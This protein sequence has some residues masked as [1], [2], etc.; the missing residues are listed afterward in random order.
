MKKK[1][2]VILSFIMLA[3]CS[4]MF[5]PTINTKK[6]AAADTSTQYASEYLYDGANVYFSTVSGG[7]ADGYGA[8]TKG[9]KAELTATANDGFELVGW[10]IKYDDDSTQFV[11]TTDTASEYNKTSPEYETKYKMNFVL[12]FT[13]NKNSDGKNDYGTLSIDFAKVDMVIN[14]VFAYVYYNVEI[15]DADQID[16]ENETLIAENTYLYYPT[17]DPVVAGEYKDAVIKIGEKYFYYGD[18][19]SDGINFYTT[20]DKNEAGQTNQ[21]K[22][23]YTKGAFRLGEQVSLNL[24]FK[25]YIDVYGAKVKN[26]T[27]SNALTNVSDELQMNQYKIQRNVMNNNT[28][29][30][31]ALFDIKKDYLL[32]LNTNLKIDFYKLFKVTLDLKIDTKSLN[33]NYLVTSGKTTAEELK[34]LLLNN[35]DFK[36]AFSSLNGESD[37]YLVRNNVSSIVCASVIKDEIG[38]YLYYQFES[39]AGYGGNTVSLNN[40]QEDTSLEINYSSASFNVAFKYI[41]KDGTDLSSVPNFALPAT[42]K[43]FTLNRGQTKTLI[44]SDIYSQTGFDY[45]GTMIEGE[46]TQHDLNTEN[47]NVSIDVEQPKNIVVFMVYSYIEYNVSVKQLESGFMLNGAYPLLSVTLNIKRGGKEMSSTLGYERVE[48]SDESDFD[49]YYEYK[50]NVMTKSS[51]IAGNKYNNKK[52]YF[53][54]SIYSTESNMINF[55]QTIRIGDQIELV[56]EVTNSEAFIYKGFGFSDSSMKTEYTELNAR[57]IETYA[58]DEDLILYSYEDYKTYSLIYNINYKQVNSKD[59][60]MAEIGTD[61]STLDYLTYDYYLQ[62]LSSDELDFDSYYEINSKELKKSSSFGGGYDS[63]K[64]YYVKTDKTSDY[65]L[66]LIGGFRYKDSIVLNAKSNFYDADANG[67]FNGDDYYF[68]FINFKKDDITFKADSTSSSDP[69]VSKF[70]VGIIGNDMVTV[71]YAEPNTTFIVSLNNENATNTDLYTVEY[72]GASGYTHFGTNTESDYFYREGVYYTLSNSKVRVSVTAASIKFGY[73]LTGLSFVKTYAGGDNSSTKSLPTLKDGKYEFELQFDGKYQYTAILNF[74]LIEYKVTV[75]QNGAVDKNGAEYKD[76]EYDFGTEDG[77]QALSL[78]VENL[79]AEI[80]IPNY[81]YVSEVLVPTASNNTNYANVDSLLA[82]FGIKNKLS[83][84]NTDVAYNYSLDFSDKLMAFKFVAGNGEDIDGDYV[85][86]ILKVNYAIHTTNIDFMY[87]L[88]ALESIRNKIYDLFPILTGDIDSIEKEYIT[89]DKSQKIGVRFKDVPFGTKI[90]NI[91]IADLLE[92]IEYQ[93]GTTASKVITFNNIGDDWS[94]DNSK[95]GENIIKDEDSLNLRLTE[96][97]IELDMTYGGDRPFEKRDGNIYTTDNNE[98]IANPE[99]ENT[100]LYSYLTFN[101]NANQANGIKFDSMYYFTRF[102]GDEEEFNRIYGVLY[103]YDRD[104]DRFVLNS[105]S[106]YKLDTIYYSKLDPKSSSISN[107]FTPALFGAI[108]KKVKIFVTHKDYLFSLNITATESGNGESLNFNPINLTPNEYANYT[109]KANNETKDKLKFNDNVVLLITLKNEPYNLAN[110]VTLKKVMLD[111]Y[112]PKLIKNYSQV[113]VDKFETGVKYYKIVDDDMVEATE[114]SPIDDV[115]YIEKEGSYVVVFKVDSTIAGLVSDDRLITSLTYAVEKKEITVQTN[116]LDSSFFTGNNGMLLKLIDEKGYTANTNP[117]YFI[118]YKNANFLSETELTFEFKGSF[119]DYFEVK[120]HNIVHHVDETNSFIVPKEQY[121]EYGI[122]DIFDA[123]SGV[124]KGV[125]VR[126]VVKGKITVEFIVAPII[127]LHEDK[128]DANPNVYIFTKE[129]QE[130]NWV[131]KSNGLTIGENANF[132]IE[133]ADEVRDQMVVTYT[134]DGYMYPLAGLPVDAGKYQVEISFKNDGWWKFIKCNYQMSLII[135]PKIVSIYYNS[136][137]VLKL[138]KIYDGTSKI[139]PEG[140]NINSNLLYNNLTVTKDYKAYKLSDTGLSIAN[141]LT[142]QMGVLD[143][144]QN[145]TPAI[146]ASNQAY[147]IKV[148]GIVLQGADFNKNYQLAADSYVTEPIMYVLQKDVYILGLKIYDKVYDGLQD[149]MYYLKDGKYEINGVLEQDKDI[150]KFAIDFDSGVF[151]FIE[152]AEVGSNKNI[153][154]DLTAA[155]TG[156]MKDCYNVIAPKDLRASIYPYAISAELENFGKI[157]IINKRGREDIT[158]QE[159]V[160]LIPIDSVNKLPKLVIREID[161]ESE[162]YFEIYKQIAPLMR[163]KKYGTGFSLVISA[164]NMDAAINNNLYLSLPVSDN[165]RTILYATTTHAG[166]LILE[167]NNGEFVVDLS[168]NTEPLKAIVILKDKT[169]LK[170]WQTTII[171]VCVAAAVGTGV[172]T[173]LVIRS[174]RKKHYKDRD[175]I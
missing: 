159:M 63:N 10:R 26:T 58:K 4:A 148:D 143:E 85:K 24:N 34:T 125:T 27:K 59:Y 62:V 69:K 152:N 157:T 13:D 29:S 30:I 3:V 165:A 102:V 77:I 44:K 136:S 167:S 5:L 101:A 25:D 16:L 97:E 23:D 65:N 53:I 90:L 140:N 40:I 56:A 68:T 12:T 158:N 155:I 126:H 137:L 135:S 103:V 92:G 54:N 46:Q 88:N 47:F 78:N 162:K 72:L 119:K 109:L 86:I 111:T 144:G 43:D 49:L 114:T 75:L 32:G 122:S 20:H 79:K 57:A 139:N 153:S 115:Y 120:D 33:E 42:S 19:Y 161:Y 124:L 81:Y 141:T 1:L 117:E 6:T 113:M 55:N 7:Y 134:K 142:Y 108:D 172:T 11:D 94:S 112:E 99:Y 41:L 80:A 28:E 146:K 36:N 8:Y 110:A 123:E 154:V 76:R 149:A 107:E 64:T 160:R 133:T 50:D 17:P 128:D 96:Y 169:Y 18:V 131:G 39:I 93:D 9:Q 21:I 91:T 73:K 60:I 15:E 147:R 74:D 129:Y 104:N 2:G 171:F 87:N 145:F 67:F 100:T 82:A 95:T 22:V 83:Q 66:I 127:K 38:K 151:K 174:K 170:R 130:E 70:N 71:N 163:G 14:P 35:I 166:E 84:S 156:E 175:T 37:V 150:T 132:D 116:V 173:F 89:T 118:N 164:N 31:S 168:K 106:E 121:D 52:V 45:V 138:E 48:T 61:V 105:S 51:E 98:K